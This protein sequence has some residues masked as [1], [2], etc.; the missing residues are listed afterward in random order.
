MREFMLCGSDI[1][2]MIIIIIKIKFLL[3]QVWHQMV[4]I[5]DRDIAVITIVR[6]ALAIA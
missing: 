6:L 4:E 3:R 1:N 5:D 2:D